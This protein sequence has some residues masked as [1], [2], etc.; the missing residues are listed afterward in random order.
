MYRIEASK[1]RVMKKALVG[2]FAIAALVGTPALAADMPA[3]APSTPAPAYD[4]TGFYI[5]VNAGWAWENTT[6]DYSV[7]GA[8]PTTASSGG[9]P[10]PLPFSF[11]PDG[12]VAGGTIG[13][14]WQFS[15]SWAFGLE[16]DWDWTNAWGAVAC[17]VITFSCQSKLS[18]L[19]S[20]RAR[21]GYVWNEFFIYA[22]GGAAWGNV[23]NQTV[24]DPGVTAG[25]SSTRL[26]YMAGLGVEAPIFQTLS[27]K[28]EW[29]YYDLGTA[30]YVVDN[31]STQNLSA[32]EW[33]STVRAGFNWR[34][35]W[36]GPISKY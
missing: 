9:V 3:K 11:T 20:A 13:Y 16:A 18:D 26:G 24:S 31:P 21:F 35:N 30:S 34:F 28:A 29:L 5:G 19:G 1:G 6:F 27:M 36:G 7:T 32:R 14:N 4:W 22:T 10:G 23:T 15:P 17:P 25:T 12:A 2:L 8:T 33:G